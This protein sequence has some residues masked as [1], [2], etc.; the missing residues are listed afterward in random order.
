VVIWLGAA[1]SAKGNFW[2]D[3][4]IENRTIASLNPIGF[5][6]SAFG[7]VISSRHSEA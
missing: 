7:L 4:T 2:L 3:S 6:V 1:G 5:G